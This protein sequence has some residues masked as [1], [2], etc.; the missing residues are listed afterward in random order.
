MTLKGDLK[1]LRKFI[2]RCLDLSTIIS[3]YQP[4]SGFIDRFFNIST[5]RQI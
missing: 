2:E 4:L 5:V 3:I 1:D